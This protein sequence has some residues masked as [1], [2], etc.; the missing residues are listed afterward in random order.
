MV[1]VANT[2]STEWFFSSASRVAE[3]TLTRLTESFPVT[4]LASSRDRAASNPS[5]FPVVGSRRE[6]RAAVWVPPTVSVPFSRIAA[7]VEPLGTSESAAGS[8]SLT[9]RST[10]PA[11]EPDE[12]PEDAGFPPGTRA[13]P[14]ELPEQAVAESAVTAA[15]TAT[16]VPQEVAARRID[17]IPPR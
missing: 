11:A 5:T 8:A 3:V 17:G 2:A 10:T 12:D 16:R 15:R 7:A 14:A 6:N 9:S 1:Y 13:S 4:Y